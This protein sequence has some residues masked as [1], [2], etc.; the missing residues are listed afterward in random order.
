MKELLRTLDAKGA[1][2]QVL[3]EVRCAYFMGFVDA[4]TIVT[5][6]SMVDSERAVSEVERMQDPKYDW[7]D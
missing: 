5:E 2:K 4:L 6:T 7:R 3:R 1:G